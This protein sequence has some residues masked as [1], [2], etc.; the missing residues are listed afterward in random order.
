MYQRV[1]YD[2]TLF[3]SNGSISNTFKS[4]E[5]VSCFVVLLSRRHA[6]HLPFPGTAAPAAH[7]EGN[8]KLHLF[9][10]HFVVVAWPGALKLYP[11]SGVPGSCSQTTL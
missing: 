3:N 7:W 11:V 6:I 1:L 9:V 2:A 5:V 8:L 10:D 4:I